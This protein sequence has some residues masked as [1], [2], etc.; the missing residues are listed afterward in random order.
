MTSTDTFNNYH[1]SEVSEF[2]PCV[3][4]YYTETE[5]I[6]KPLDDCQHCKG[7]GEDS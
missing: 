7:R 2:C 5:V 4:I 6:L 1:I 3:S